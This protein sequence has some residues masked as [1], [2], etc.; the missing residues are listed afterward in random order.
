VFYAAADQHVRSVIT[1][2][3]AHVGEDAHDFD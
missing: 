2:M 1:D 3:A